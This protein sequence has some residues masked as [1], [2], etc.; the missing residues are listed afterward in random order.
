[1]NDRGNVTYGATFL[2]SHFL[3]LY[4]ALTTFSYLIRSL[5]F[6]SDGSGAGSSGGRYGNVRLDRDLNDPA[7]LIV[8]GVPTRRIIFDIRVLKTKQKILLGK[9]HLPIVAPC[10][11]AA[12]GMWER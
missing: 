8:S 11:K 4:Y 9:M 1:L 3:T 5:C 12:D 7:S 10:S 6:L 2:L